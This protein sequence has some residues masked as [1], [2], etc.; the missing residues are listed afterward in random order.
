MPL[1]TTQVE[2]IDTARMQFI[3]ELNKHIAQL[4][5]ELRISELIMHSVIK[6]LSSK[7][8]A[9]QKLDEEMHI[10]RQESARHSPHVETRNQRIA[11]QV[12]DAL[13]RAS[14]GINLV[15]RLEQVIEEEQ[16]QIEHK[17]KHNEQ[18]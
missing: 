10:V 4:R 6:S 2:H 7:D 11:D 18:D 15:D 13:R 9:M 1:H 5:E 12:E 8:D 3:N 14:Q 16:Q 17:P